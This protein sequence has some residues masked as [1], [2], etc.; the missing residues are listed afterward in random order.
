MIRRKALLFAALS[1]AGAEGAS[2]TAKLPGGRQMAAVF[3]IGAG[4]DDGTGAQAPVL[5]SRSS[6]D[7]RT[8]DVVPERRGG[9]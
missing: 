5:S 2:E 8:A 6:A 4:D 3:Q 9:Q 1:A 7:P